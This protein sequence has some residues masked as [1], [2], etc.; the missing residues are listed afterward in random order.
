MATQSDLTAD[1]KA[2]LAQ[3][4]KT[5]GEIAAVQEGVDT[6]KTQV[7][8]LEAQIAAGGNVTPELMRAVSDVKAQAQV[9]DDLIPDVPTPAPTA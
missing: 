8:D 3:Q 6:L 5:A 4:K 2:V 9:V 7:A 1:L